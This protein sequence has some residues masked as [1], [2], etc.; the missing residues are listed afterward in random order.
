M[1]ARDEGHFI[2]GFALIAAVL[3]GIFALLT[4]DLPWWEV[5]LGICGIAGLF[6][7]IHA[8]VN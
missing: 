7:M 5:G 2:V 1:N 6:G 3:I 8:G 4:S